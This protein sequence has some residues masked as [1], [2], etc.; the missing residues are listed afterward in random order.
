MNA[1][2]FFF[3]PNV[4]RQYEFQT[5]IID[6]AY[7]MHSLDCE[8]LLKFETSLA[9]SKQTVQ[10]ENSPGNP[11]QFPNWISILRYTSKLRL[12]RHNYRFAKARR[13]NIINIIYIRM[14]T[15]VSN[16][17]TKL[18]KGKIKSVAEFRMYIHMCSC[19]PLS[20]S[21]AISINLYAIS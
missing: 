9:N 2:W 14:Y 13:L 4:I 12:I 17:L 7:S 21:I 15:P 1:R 16:A 10:N 8:F 3:N 19:M 20:A 11:R 18:H 6:S 5:E